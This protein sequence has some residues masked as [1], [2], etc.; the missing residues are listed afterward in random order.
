M[1]IS[2]PHVLIGLFGLSMF[3]FLSSLNVIQ[4][5]IQ[6]MRGSPPLLLPGGQEPRDWRAQ[7]PRIKANKT[8]RK[9]TSEM[10][11][12]DILLYS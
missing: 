1:L 8:N 6:A 10:I 5:K 12:N 7:K 11:P 9:K 2:A 3:S 4:I